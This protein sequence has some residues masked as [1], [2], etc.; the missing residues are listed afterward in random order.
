MVT[1]TVKSQ[2]CGYLSGK[3][4]QMVSGEWEERAGHALFLVLDV[5][6][7]SICKTVLFYMLC[8]V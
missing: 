5:G 6:F 3:G 1:I 2:D 8:S 7:I 4:T